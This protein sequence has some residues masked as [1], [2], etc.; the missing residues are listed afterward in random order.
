[1]ASTQIARKTPPII[2]R[3]L[4][5]PDF[6]AAGAAARG[7]AGLVAGWTG[8]A[9]CWID[10][11]G[12]SARV[13]HFPQNAPEM[14]LPQ[15]LQKLAMVPSLHLIGPGHRSSFRPKYL[16]IIFKTLGCFRQFEVIPERMR[17]HFEHDQIR[18]IAVSPIYSY[19]RQL[20]GSSL[21]A[22]VAG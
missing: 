13:P 15:F 17:Q 3:T 19:R 12:S 2:K 14:G 4:P 16:A 7:I 10:A 1:M 18:V 6:F 11:G 21:A 8:G 22:R 9:A 5:T 20:I